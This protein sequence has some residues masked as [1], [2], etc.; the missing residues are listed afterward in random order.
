[1]IRKK[2]QITLGDKV[3]VT[4]LNSNID[5]NNSVPNNEQVKPGKK[6]AM[7]DRLEMSDKAQKLQN[8]KVKDPDVFKQKIADNFYDLDEVLNNVA[9][10]ILKDIE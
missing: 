3:K 10:K 2:Q 9:A 6:I 7:Q 5:Y 8:N 4:D 1:M